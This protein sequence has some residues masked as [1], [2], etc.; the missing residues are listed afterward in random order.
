MEIKYSPIPIASIPC[1]WELPVAIY[2]KIAGR[3]LKYL[4]Q[5]D[6]LSSE[7]VLHFMAHH[8][9]SLYVR[10]EDEEIFNLA[11]KKISQEHNIKQKNLYPTLTQENI[12]KNEKMIEKIYQTF[13]SETLSTEQVVQIRAE[14]ESF[15]R[16]VKER[17]LGMEVLAQ[18]MN[19]NPQ[20]AIHS[21]NVANLS[22]FIA[23]VLGYNEQLILENLYIGGLF[24]DYAK[25]RI[26]PEILEN[27]GGSLYSHA[28][29][30]HPLDGAKMLKKLKN[31]HEPVVSIIEQH[32]EFHDGSGYPKGLKGEEILPLAGIVSFANIF[33]NT[34]AETMN[35]LHRGQ[36]T[37]DDFEMK[38]L[39]ISF[40]ALDNSRKRFKAIFVDKVLPSLKVALLK[41]RPH[42]FAFS[43]NT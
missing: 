40:K 38:A 30:Q 37:Q 28:I 27:K 31:I 15:I 16:E 13:A 4:P 7:K 36:S 18:L 9:Q 5:G 20:V 17:K 32:E 19:W 22:V 12:D 34:V 24:H 1:N 3:Y 43:T 23:L 14:T 33:D 11:L 35:R 39:Q 10:E 6:E 2:L 8:L 41:D 42:P 21:V 25:A 29:N 26:A